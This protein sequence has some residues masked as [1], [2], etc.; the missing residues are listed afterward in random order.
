MPDLDALGEVGQLVD[1]EDAAVGPR[2]EA[3]VERELVGEVSALGD[4]DRVDL[5][6]QVGDRG[7]G[8]GELLAEPFARGAPSGSA[9]SSPISST[10]S[11]ACFDTGSYGSS[12]ISLPA[13][14]GIHSSSSPVSER[15]MR[16]LACPR[17]PR[18]ITSWP[19]E[20]GVLELRHHGVLVAGHA[21]EQRLAR[22]DLLD[23]V[24]T[25]LLLDRP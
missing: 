17:S 10:R 2:H 9:S 23:R 1:R 11:R 24:L 21:V 6:D 7:V 3:V 12:L 4:L 13:M 5:A 14:I 19:G 8:R 18:K 15:I 16:V 20:Q 25:N 22:R